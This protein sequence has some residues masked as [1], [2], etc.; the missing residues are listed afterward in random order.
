MLVL[1]PVIKSITFELRCRAT[2]SS[3]LKNE[4]DFLI[5]LSRFPMPALEFLDLA[6]IRAFDFFSYRKETAA[7]IK[8]HLR[9]ALLS[10]SPRLKQLSISA[11]EA[12]VAA[13]QGVT[14][15]ALHTLTLD[16][17][18][19]DFETKITS[20]QRRTF[21]VL[22]ALKSSAMP[23]LRTLK[24]VQVLQIPCSLSTTTF[25]G[26]AAGVTDLNI[27][28]HY[29]AA[30][31]DERATNV[32]AFLAMFRALRV[33]SWNG[34][35]SLPRVSTILSQCP[36]LEQVALNPNGT[37]YR[38]E[39]CEDEAVMAGG[40]DAGS[41]G[42]EDEDEE[43]EDELPK[44]LKTL[45]FPKIEVPDWMYKAGKRDLE[46]EETDS[47]SADEEF[48]SEQRDFMGKVLKACDLLGSRL[49]T[50]TLMY[51]QK[52]I[53]AEQLELIG[54]SCPH[55]RELSVVMQRDSMKGLPVLCQALA[56]TL[57]TLKIK[58]QVCGRI[59]TEEAWSDFVRGIENTNCL[60][61]LTLQ[62]SA[63]EYTPDGGTFHHMIDALEKSLRAIGESARH[64]EFL[65]PGRYVETS[66]N[67]LI[68]SHTWVLHHAALLAP[69]L[70][71]FSFGM[72]LRKVTYV[73][74][75]RTTAEQARTLIANFFEL[76][77]LVS[78]QM[79]D[80]ES[81]GGCGILAGELESILAASEADEDSDILQATLYPTY[82]TKI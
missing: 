70:K 5:S 77:D 19:Q 81:I 76:V 42:E 49:Q 25:A 65:M 64:V 67:A 38:M 47:E 35:C 6:S 9:S 80:L 45:T 13:I 60:S 14:F 16:F 23:A 53:P 62:S 82:H 10:H 39:D 46:D 26:L 66:I 54:S 22:S 20:L 34:W 74:A 50:L 27:Q 41:V 55:L 18:T 61:T 1:T 17:L 58:Y 44:W 36:E 72:G 75:D 69:H 29:K 15:P 43:D 68:Q 11:H 63:D 4:A 8:P 40:T 78:V 37:F 12:V 51:D 52:S 56:D 30:D 71:K 31:K 73:W 7:K 57:E 32:V 2:A 79:P 24:L 59:M 21:N 33:L 28:H 48:H 3:S